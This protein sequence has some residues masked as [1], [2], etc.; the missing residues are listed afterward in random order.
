MWSCCNLLREKTCRKECIC[1]NKLRYGLPNITARWPRRKFVINWKV[2]V[3]EAPALMLDRGDTNGSFSKESPR[4]PTY[5]F[6]SLPL[7]GE[8][9]HQVSV[10]LILDFDLLNAHC[11][12]VVGQS[13]GNRRSRSSREWEFKSNDAPFISCV[14]SIQD[15]IRESRILSG[16][17][18]GG[19]S[20]LFAPSI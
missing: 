17:E 19:G 14:L 8:E 16:L 1:P 5:R 12:F 9:C 13:A 10:R 4:F 20:L 3:L 11:D 2:S 18:I 15:M 6:G 7:Q